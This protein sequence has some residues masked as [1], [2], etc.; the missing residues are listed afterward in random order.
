MASHP[1]QNWQDF[2]E[3]YY[4]RIYRYGYFYFKGNTAEAED[5]TQKTFLKAWRSFGSLRSRESEKAWIYSIARNVCHDR[6]R[7]WKRHL[8]FKKELPQEASVPAQELV[9]PALLRCI[10]ELP[11]RQREVFLLRHW[12]EFSTDETADQL[13]ISAGAVKSHLKRAITALREKLIHEFEGEVSTET[14]VYTSQSLDKGN[15]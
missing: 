10:D 13:G 4:D 9:S 8:I 6:S 14:G 2:L 7:W 15:F 3:R 5:A 12:H 11:R 1:D